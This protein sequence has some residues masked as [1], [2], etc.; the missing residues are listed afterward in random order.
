MILIVKQVTVRWPQASIHRGKGR[1]WMW[2]GIRGH[3]EVVE[4][5]RLTLEAGR[6]ASTYL[7][8]GPSGIGKRS[9][10]LKLAQ[11]L[12]CQRTPDER[13]EPCGA[14]E[15]CRLLLAGNHPDV[16]AVGKPAGK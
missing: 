5:F 8:V 3:D 14:C 7:F 9:F 6:L 10:A 4:R 1:S 16:I 11:A 12:L 13:L 2:Q 15:S